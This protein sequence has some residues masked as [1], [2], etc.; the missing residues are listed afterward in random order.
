MNSDLSMVKR[1]L[2]NAQRDIYDL[3]PHDE[4]TTQ[5]K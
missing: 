1:Q 5:C 3:Y 4:E 2:H